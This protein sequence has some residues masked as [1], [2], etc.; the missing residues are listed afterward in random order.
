MPSVRVSF[1][2]LLPKLVEMGT[3]LLRVFYMAL[4]PIIICL[5][6]SIRVVLNEYVILLLFYYLAVKI[7]VI[8]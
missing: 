5:V 4:L 6:N 8:E 7:H 1:V 3:C 2:A